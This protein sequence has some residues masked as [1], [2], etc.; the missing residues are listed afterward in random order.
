MFSACHAQADA[1]IS[2]RS[3]REWYFFCKAI[4]EKIRRLLS[5]PI[6]SNLHFPEKALLGF[7]VAGVMVCLP[8]PKRANVFFTLASLPVGHRKMP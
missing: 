8:C 3:P 6:H 5:S 4:L 1:S 7:A 2:L